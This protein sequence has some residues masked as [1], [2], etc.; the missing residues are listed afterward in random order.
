MV[1]Q[2]HPFEQT[3]VDQQG[4]DGAPKENTTEGKARRKFSKAPGG[5]RTKTGCL[6]ESHGT[7]PV[8]RVE[9]ADVLVSL[10]QASCQVYRGEAGLSKL[11][12][13]QT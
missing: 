3:Q 7:I 6:S 1:E 2:V 12:Q 4:D 8:R 10:S 9:K 11:Y 13:G 5:R